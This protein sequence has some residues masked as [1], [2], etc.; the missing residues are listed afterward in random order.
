MYDIW[1]CLPRCEDPTN[2]TRRSVED[3]SVRG[4]V[5]VCGAAEAVKPSMHLL[6]RR[7]RRRR[8]GGRQRALVA[9][10]LL[11]EPG[12]DALDGLGRV[13]VRGPLGG[14][15]AV[16]SVAEASP[17]DTLLGLEN[18]QIP[19]SVP[20]RTAS[21]AAST[22]GMGS[23]SSPRPPRASGASARASRKQWRF[24]EPTRRETRGSRR[25]FR[26]R[27]LSAAPSTRGTGSRS[28]P[29]PPRTSGRPNAGPRALPCSKSWASRD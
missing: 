23:R 1:I 16:S 17:K 9:V 20:L 24:P 13:A 21:A 14:V 4:H 2:V 6:P 5:D 27:T 10:Q 29:R 25:R 22:R 11:V 28:S 19:E 15:D 3:R 26:A 18:E 7:R 12:H 8:G